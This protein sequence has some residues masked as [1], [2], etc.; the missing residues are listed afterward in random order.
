VA[1]KIS[2]GDK[3]IGCFRDGKFEDARARVEFANGDILTRATYEAGVLTEGL[4][5][6]KTGIYG[7]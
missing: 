2:T 1:T 5:E 4:K 7:G 3:Y 6:S